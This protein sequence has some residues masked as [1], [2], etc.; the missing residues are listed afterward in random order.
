MKLKPRPWSVSTVVVAAM[1]RTDELAE[2]EE[3]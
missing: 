3:E 1:R 2:G